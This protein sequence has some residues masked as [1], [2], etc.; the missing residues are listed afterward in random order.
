[1]HQPRER[2]GHARLTVPRTTIRH[3]SVRWMPSSLASCAVGSA[4]S[5]ATWASHSGATSSR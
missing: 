2:D 4:A 3:G 5:M 1:M